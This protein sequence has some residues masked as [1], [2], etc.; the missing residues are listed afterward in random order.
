MALSIVRVQDSRSPVTVGI[1]QE[2]FLLIPGTSDYVTNGYVITAAAV[3]F[4]NVQLVSI[5]GTNATGLAWN[6][7]AVFALAQ[8]GTGGPGFG[9]YTQFLFALFV[10]TTGVQLANGG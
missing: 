4:K 3:G 8:V 6:P 1:Q 7:Y 10:I 2:S 9:G 5:D